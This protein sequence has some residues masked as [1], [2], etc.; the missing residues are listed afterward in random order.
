MNEK[1]LLI[2]STNDY[3]VPYM[4]VMIDSILRHSTQEKFYEIIVLHS[5][6][7]KENQDKLA[8]QVETHQNFA[9][10]LLDV[11][12]HIAGCKFYTDNREFFEKEAYYRLLTPWLLSEYDRAIYLDGDMIAMTDISALMDID[13][14]GNLIAAVRDFCGLAECY[15]PKSDRASYMKQMLRLDDYNDYYNSGL[16][17][18]NLKELRKAFSLDQVLS[19][20][21]SKQWEFHDQDI[22]NVL[23]QGRTKMLDPRWN[24]IQN[25]GRHHFLPPWLRQEWEQSCKAPYIIHYGGHLKPWMF[26]RVSHSRLFWAYARKNLF[27]E[28]ITLRKRELWKKSKAY[29]RKYMQQLIFPLGHPVRRVISGVFKP[30]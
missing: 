4:S 30:S 10:S 12:V 3:F 11:S 23:T 29:R 9:L 24:V 15:C 5:E 8:K 17:L 2:F 14:E 22:L 6:I 19:L 28:E 25:Y 18:L 26:K 21:S 7:K 16:L 13:M 20:A 27:Y 1:V